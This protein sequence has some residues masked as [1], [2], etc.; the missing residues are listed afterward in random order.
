MQKLKAFYKNNRVF[1]ILMGISSLCLIVILSI[2]VIYFFD[3]TEGDAY[4]N[5]LNGIETVKLGDEK[6]K[7]IENMLLD[8]DK[9]ATVNVHLI[10]RIV[11]INCYLSSGKSSDAK[12]IA[13][14]VL[15]AFNEDEKAF[16]DLSFAFAK[17]DEE[18]N[19]TGFPMMGYK[20]SDNTIISWI[21]LSE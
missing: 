11:Y 8:Q 6:L 20:K 12:N 2:V 13:I 1:V 4:G 21:N 17:V 16:Y 9:V 5:R 14:K 3:Q 19:K 10:G 7:S 15:D 18:E